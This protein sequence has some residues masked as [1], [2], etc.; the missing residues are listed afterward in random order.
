MPISF[1]RG[2]QLGD[3]LVVVLLDIGGSKGEL[4]VLG[5]ALSGDYLHI[6]LE[7]IGDLDGVGAVQAH[8]Q[9]GLI[10]VV[11]ILNG[12]LCTELDVLDFREVEEE[13]PLG[14]RGNAAV[15]DT[16]EALLDGV[17]E[18][19]VEQGRQGAV[20]DLII[21]GVSGI[22]HDL[23]AVDKNHK[24]FV[25]YVNDRTV[26]NEV[27]AALFVLASASLVDCLTGNEDVVIAHGRGLDDFQP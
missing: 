9:L 27:F 11:K 25:I 24:L 23:A 6:E 8:E 20:V 3:E 16:A 10:E 15:L 19:S 22:V 14:G 26:G 5:D 17:A 13:N 1:V 4:A 12:I 2:A 7:G 21:T 18:L